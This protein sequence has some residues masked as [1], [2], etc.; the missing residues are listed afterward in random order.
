MTLAN[1][2]IK[3]VPSQMVGGKYPVDAQAIFSCYSGYNREGC[4][5]TT[6]QTLG[7]WAHDKPT[8]V[9]GEEI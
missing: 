4:E 2:W 3:Y 6:C 9:K 1:G 5:R 7:N 8:C